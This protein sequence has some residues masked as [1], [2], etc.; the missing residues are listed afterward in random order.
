MVPVCPF[1]TLSVILSE[2]PRS[3]RFHTRSTPS[4]QIPLHICNYAAHMIQVDADILCRPKSPPLLQDICCAHVLETS[5]AL[6]TRDG[7]TDGKSLHVLSPAVT[8]HTTFSVLC[9]IVNLPPG[10]ICLTCVAVSQ[11]EDGAAEPSSLKS[12]A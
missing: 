1:T 2:Q 8:V 10:K 3:E 5:S 4:S 7:P 12:S 9:R 11:I 6:C